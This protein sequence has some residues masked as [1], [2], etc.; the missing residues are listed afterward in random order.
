MPE[1]LPGGR[2]TVHPEPRPATYVHHG[3][4]VFR[5]T[6]RRTDE[7]LGSHVVLQVVDDSNAWAGAPASS[8]TTAPRSPTASRTSTPPT[9]AP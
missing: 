7:N 8:R 2:M 9:S 1:W 6:G 3:A 4:E 5:A